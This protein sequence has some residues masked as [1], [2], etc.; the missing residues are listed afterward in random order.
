M[1]KSKNIRFFV[2]KEGFT[3]GA[4]HSPFR[5][6]GAATNASIFH[7]SFHTMQYGLKRCFQCIFFSRKE[8]N[9]RRGKRGVEKR[10][11]HRY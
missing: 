9:Y 11:R 2:K 3:I 1:K 7:V 8:D 6:N 4:D 5:D 10:S